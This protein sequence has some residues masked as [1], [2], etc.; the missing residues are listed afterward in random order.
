[1]YQL[2]VLRRITSSAHFEP[3]RRPGDVVWVRDEKAA[4]ALI[5]EG[6]CQWVGIPDAP[7]QVVAPAPA[8][9]AESAPVVVREGEAVIP[10]AETDAP[11]SV[12]DRTDGPSTVSPS[13]NESGLAILSSASAAALV[14]PERR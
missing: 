3:N 11:K 12:G 4:E 6:L 7:P 9:A 8:P 10:V 2:R 14:S 13:S 5:R 1:M